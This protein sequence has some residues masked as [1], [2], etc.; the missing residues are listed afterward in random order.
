MTS[1]AR[2]PRVSRR[3]A[4]GLGV[5]ALAVGGVAVVTDLAGAPAGP[6]GANATAL[7]GMRSSTGHT[8]AALPGRAGRIDVY[9]PPGQGPF[10]ASVTERRG[11]TPVPCPRPVR[12]WGHVCSGAGHRQEA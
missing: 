1:T 9:R 6:L 5:G 2:S 4:L 3:A 8:Y 11:P 12:S 7:Y 10:P